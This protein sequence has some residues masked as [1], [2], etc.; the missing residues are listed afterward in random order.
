MYSPGT[1]LR[2]QGVLAERKARP[3]QDVDFYQI[4][5]SIRARTRAT[6]PVVALR[7][8]NQPPGGD[9]LATRWR[10]TQRMGGRIPGRAPEHA[11]GE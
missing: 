9:F 3:H 1:L 5:P 11:R 4:I 8:M 10:E 7:L 2:I 6:A